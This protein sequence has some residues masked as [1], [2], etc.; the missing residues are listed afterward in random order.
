[1]S[2][3]FVSLFAVV[4]LLLFLFFVV[5]V[6]LLL[7]LWGFFWGGGGVGDIL[8]YYTYRRF[9]FVLHL[10]VSV[11]GRWVL[12][13]IYFILSQYVKLQITC[14]DFEIS[15]SFAPVIKTFV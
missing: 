6:L 8:C 4:L 7:F 10:S 14:A 1:M 3:L 11:T 9:W 13:Y 5:V 2:C 15:A 12:L